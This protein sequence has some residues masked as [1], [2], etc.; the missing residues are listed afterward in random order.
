M[1]WEDNGTE[2]SGVVTFCFCLLQFDSATF[3][4]QY[5]KNIIWMRSALGM[6]PQPATVTIRLC[7]LQLPL[8]KDCCLLWKHDLWTLGNEHLPFWLLSGGQWCRWIWSHMALCH[9]S[10]KFSPISRCI[11]ASDTLFAKS[12]ALL[13]YQI[14]PLMLVGFP[15]NWLYC[16][17][18]CLVSL[19]N[20]YS[21]VE[22]FH[23]G[24]TVVDLLISLSAHSPLY[25]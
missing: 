13:R 4:C 3:P 25:C 16:S 6:A 19:A 2:E 8:A 20:F 9:Y 1:F 15:W 12:E 10:N 11:L 18:Y 22:F 24:I 17:F 21:I 7:H 14:F 5:S 23:I